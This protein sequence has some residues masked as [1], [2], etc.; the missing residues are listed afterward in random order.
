MT[1]LTN[2]IK[3]EIIKNALVKAGIQ[4][5]KSQLRAEKSAL[6][7]DVRIAALGG[8]ENAK[9]IDDKYAT[10]LAIVKELK[11]DVDEYIHIGNATDDEIYPAFGGQRTRLRYG[12]DDQ[13][14]VLRLL[15]PQNSKCLFPADHELSK[16]FAQ[17]VD[18]ESSIEKKEAEIKANVKAALDSVTTIKK[19][20]SV[21][22]EVKEILPEG[23]QEQQTSLPAVKVENLNSL[24]GLPTESEAA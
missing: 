12:R 18:K 22:P 8:A 7:N 17:I 9:K 11:S 15:T 14:A 21:W 16:R 24:I 23:E 13:G 6:A 1:R 4:E 19:L 5:E 10:A 20:I 3:S 2:H